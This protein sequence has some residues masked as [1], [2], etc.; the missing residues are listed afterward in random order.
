M[1]FKTAGAIAL[2]GAL[3]AAGTVVLEPISSVR[4]RVPDDLLGDVLGDLS[5][6]RGRVQ[7]TDAS[8][9]HEQVVRALVPDAELRRYA[10]ELRALTSGRAR[11]SASPAG[12]DVAPA[13]VR[14]A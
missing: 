6:R 11:F 3:E 1:A 12:Y 13:T 7:G 2:R 5:A 10:V 8:G 9:G 4:V 14:S